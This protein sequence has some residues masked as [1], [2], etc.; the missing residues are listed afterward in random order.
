MDYSLLVG[1]H[2]CDAPDQQQQQ[3]KQLD[4][5]DNQAA[6]V[7]GNVVNSSDEHDSSGSAATPPDSPATP[8]RNRTISFTAELD[9][10][11][12]LFAIKCAERECLLICLLNIC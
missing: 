12:E 7:H 8:R 3:P 9:P 6:D 10:C 1:I 4:L 11:L 5:G 2:N